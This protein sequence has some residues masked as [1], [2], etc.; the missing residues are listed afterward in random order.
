MG[1]VVDVSLGGSVARD[2]VAE[3]CVGGD[4]VLFEGRK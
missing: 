4:M 1:V 3:D 2:G